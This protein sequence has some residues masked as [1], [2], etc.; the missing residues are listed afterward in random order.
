MTTVATTEHWQSLFENWPDV[1]PRKGSVVTK[2]GEAIPFVD[3]LISLGLLLIER[4]G[5]DA[6]GTRKIIVAYDSIGMIKLSAA[7]EMSIFQSMGF[8]PSM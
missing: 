3:F 2:Q 5:P 7:G 1:I 4:D 6:A 8:Q